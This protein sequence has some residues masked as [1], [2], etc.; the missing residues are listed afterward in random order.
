MR[1]FFRQNLVC[2]KIYTEKPLKRNDRY[3]RK[4]HKKCRINERQLRNS[5]PP[6]SDPHQT[7]KNSSHESDKDSQNSI[8]HFCSRSVCSYALGDVFHRWNDQ[9]PYKRCVANRVGY[10][11]VRCLSRN[12]HWSFHMDINTLIR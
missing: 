7:Q 1:V 10:C 2:P 6:L 5:H 9:S 8:T 11:T 4:T 12:R 3:D